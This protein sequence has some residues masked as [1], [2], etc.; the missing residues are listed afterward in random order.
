MTPYGTQ[1]RNF[2]PYNPWALPVYSPQYPQGSSGLNLQSGPGGTTGLP[3][4]VDFNH[5]MQQLMQQ[6]AAQQAL[7]DS[8]NSR[9]GSLSTGTAATPPPMV[10]PWEQGYDTGGTSGMSAG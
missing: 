8:L 4:M 7:I 1:P 10:T 3:D 2:S 5:Q 6:L 9:M